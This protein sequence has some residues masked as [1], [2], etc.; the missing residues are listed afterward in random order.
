MVRKPKLG[1]VLCCD[2]APLSIVDDWLVSS[3]K[4]AGLHF[5]LPPLPN[6]F[7]SD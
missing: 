5:E 7:K 1:D 2:A 3:S 4:L 6:T